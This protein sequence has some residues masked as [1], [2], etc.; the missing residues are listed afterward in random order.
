MYV[1]FD[2]IRG[3]NPHNI[4][5]NLSKYLEFAKQAPKILAFNY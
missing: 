4:N 2:E 3:Q 1:I 5:A